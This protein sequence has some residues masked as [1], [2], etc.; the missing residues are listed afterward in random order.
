MTRCFNTNTSESDSQIGRLV[1]LMMHMH[2]LKGKKN[3]PLLHFAK[4]DLYSSQRLSCE[5]CI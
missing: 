5:K 4:E 3:K 1:K 2:D